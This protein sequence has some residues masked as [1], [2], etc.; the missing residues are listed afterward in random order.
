M[1]CGDF[2][3]SIREAGNN[4]RC[5]YCIECCGQRA[6]PCVTVEIASSGSHLF[7]LPCRWRLSR[8]DGLL[9]IAQ[10]IFA[11]EHFLTDEKGRR[12]ERTTIHSVLGELQQSR[13]HLRLL[14]SRE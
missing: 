13:L 5:R 7:S 2:A 9:N 4:I 3:D 8:D 12:A 1:N 11:E 10:L 6:L 14:R